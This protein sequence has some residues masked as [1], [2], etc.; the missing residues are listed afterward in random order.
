M[1]AKMIHERNGQRTFVVV[2]ATAAAQISAIGALID[3]ELK[4]FDW[5]ARDYRK[6][7]LPSRSR[8]PRY[9][10]CKITDSS[11]RGGEA[12]DAIQIGAAPVL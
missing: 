12:D 2:L 7:S 8:S 1:E 3:V 11:L 4:Y 5:D 6:K 9:T 10:A